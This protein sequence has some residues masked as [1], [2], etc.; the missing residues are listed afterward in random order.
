VE[1]LLQAKDLVAVALVAVTRRQRRA[2]ELYYL[3]ELTLRETGER[4]GKTESNVCSL[5]NAGLA[6]AR[7]ALAGREEEL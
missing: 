4:L 3:G 7:K 2:L 5:V 1:H 6:R